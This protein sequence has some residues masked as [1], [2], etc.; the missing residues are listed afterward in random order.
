MP[1]ARANLIGLGVICREVVDIE[2]LY[3]AINLG[4]NSLQVDAVVVSFY[5]SCNSAVPNLT[6]KFLF[7]RTAT[8]RS[9]AQ[10]LEDF[11]CPPTVF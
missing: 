9:E 3:L 6:L 10:V 1:A 2:E 5:I 11:K 4:L 8:F 7:Q